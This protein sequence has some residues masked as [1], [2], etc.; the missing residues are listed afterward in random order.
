MAVTVDKIRQGIRD[1]GL[2]GR[3]VC[4]HSSLRS[5]GPVEGG[6]RAIIDSLL[7]EESTVLVPAFSS[8][9][10]EVPPPSDEQFARNGL[11]RF[12]SE[13]FV[14]NVRRVYTSDSLDIDSNMARS[15]L[16]YSSWPAMSAVLIL[17]GPSPQSGLRRAPLIPS[18]TGLDPHG[19]LYRLVNADGFVFLMGVGLDKMTAIHLAEQEADVGC[20]FGGPT[21]QMDVSSK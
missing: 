5:F 10:Y 14:A 17:Y 16:R 11:G 8:E 19:P 6:A 21:D 15:Q 4:V 7:Y 1:L 20:S 2:S 12:E 13:K 3:P 18:N 9:M